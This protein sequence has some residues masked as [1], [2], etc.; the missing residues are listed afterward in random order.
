M[1]MLLSLRMITPPQESCRLF[2]ELL[3]LL[4]RHVCTLYRHVCTVCTLYRLLSLYPFY[5]DPRF[6]GLIL[7]S[8][9]FSLGPPCSDGQ[10]EGPGGSRFFQQFYL[11]HRVRL[12]TPS[13]WRCSTTCPFLHNLFC[14]SS[15]S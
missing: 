8:F 9:D 4:Y 2:C 15:R 7:C 10:S 14:C 13:V 6:P 3:F 1:I 5:K 12:Q 11:D